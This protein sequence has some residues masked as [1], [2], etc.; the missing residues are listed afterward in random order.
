MCGFHFILYGKSKFLAEKWCMTV[1][2][3]FQRNS[4]IKII[5]IQFEEFWHKSNAV[6]FNICINGTNNIGMVFNVVW[7][8]VWMRV[9][10]AQQSVS[11]VPNRYIQLYTKS[12]IYF[13]FNKS[14]MLFIFYTK[15]NYINNTFIVQNCECNGIVWNCKIDN[16]T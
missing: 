8:W 6:N 3:I 2:V 12:I 7:M 13:T 5:T 11:V 15:L 16:L 4:Y 9:R 1:Q 10:T 14:L